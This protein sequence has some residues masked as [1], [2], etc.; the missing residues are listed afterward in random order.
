MGDAKMDNLRVG[1]DSHLKLKFCDSK[2]SSD[3]GLLAY[4]EL[5]EALGLTEMGN[6][7]VNN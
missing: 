3:A 4:R 7:G 1:F 5:D 2:V 6:S